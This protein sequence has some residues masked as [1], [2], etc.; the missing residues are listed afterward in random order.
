M[1]HPPHFIELF[2]KLSI[3]VKIPI[4]TL[5]ITFKSIY[6]KKNLTS[7]RVREEKSTF[8]DPY[9]DALLQYYTLIQ[10]KLTEK[11]L[12]F[13]YENII[14][15]KYLSEITFLRDFSHTF[16]SRKIVRCK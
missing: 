11:S 14:N 16:S 9:E 7:L 8:E 13:T 6:R 15:V 1:N 2:K 3:K 5:C 4:Q 12:S 10:R